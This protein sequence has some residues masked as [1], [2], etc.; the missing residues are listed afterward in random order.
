MVNQEN[1]DQGQDQGQGSQSPQPELCE[2][3]GVVHSAQEEMGKVMRGKSRFHSPSC[4]RC[5]KARPVARV[6]PFSLDGVEI[7]RPWKKRAIAM[8]GPEGADHPSYLS[9]TVDVNQND[10]DS[11]TEVVILDD[12]EPTRSTSPMPSTS[13]GAGPSI[14]SNLYRQPSSPTN[15]SDSLPDIAVE[16][17]TG[18]ATIEYSGIH[19]MVCFSPTCT[20]PGCTA[21]TRARNVDSITNVRQQ[22]NSVLSSTQQVVERSR[23]LIDHAN[24]LGA[25][26]RRG[27]LEGIRR[28]GG[29]SSSAM[30]GG[31][32]IPDSPASPESGT[33]SESEV[34]TD[35]DSDLDTDTDRDSDSS[36]GSWGRRVVH[37][38]PNALHMHTDS[39][40]SSSDEGHDASPPV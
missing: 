35:S 8:L 21:S 3:C 7:H 2:K 27:D 14:L 34:D 4:P 31:S 1:Q 15:S 22:V 38:S 32:G 36:D 11:D 33:G 23:V 10:S 29:F 28:L 24:T 37:L 19:N 40:S 13:S 17:T 25:L 9:V 26:M 20:M 12:D 5:L 39:S 18:F 30:P 16:G 6:V